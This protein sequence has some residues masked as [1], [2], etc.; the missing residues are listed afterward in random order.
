MNL[1]N[2][3]VLTNLVRYIMVKYKIIDILERNT[4]TNNGY[5][6]FVLFISISLL[7]KFKNIYIAVFGGIFGYVLRYISIKLKIA[8]PNEPLALINSIIFFIFTLIFGKIL[9]LK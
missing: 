7:L 9:E 2:F 6:V 8:K 4:D 1:I 3:L 5:K